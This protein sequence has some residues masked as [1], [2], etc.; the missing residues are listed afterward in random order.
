[1]PAR[2]KYPVPKGLKRVSRRL[3]TGEVR[4]YWYHRATGKRVEG[5]LSAPDG[6]LEVQALDARAKALEAAL[7]HLAGSYADLWEK[8]RQSPEW[9][10]LRPRTRSDYQAVRDWLGAAAE[11]K[12]L[13]SLTTAAVYQLRD[14]AAAEKGRR[15]ANYVVQVLRLTL[16]WGRKRAHCKDNPAKEVELIRK[17]IGEAKVNRAWTAAEVEAFAKAAPFH[18]QIPFALGLFAGMRQGDA[19]MTTW[20]AYDGAGLRWIA[21]KNGE[22]CLAPVS[23]PFKALLD[24]AKNDRGQAVQIAVTMGKQP[25]SASGFR[26]S[27]FKIVRRL[28]KAGA[29][30]PGCTFHGLRLTIASG[31]REAGE[32]DFRVAAAIGDRSTAMASLYG[33]D[34]DRESAQGTVLEGSQKRFANVD[35]K[36][37]PAVKGK[38]TLS[39]RGQKC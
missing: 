16:E 39:G 23:G 15:F 31:A 14:K 4:V 19:L 24:A 32:S 38:R 12:K 5:D 8:Y 21:S 2:R 22:P 35:W 10:A 36:T 33:R 29:M 26:A 34:A 20:S 27:F 11:R 9:R 37:A 17:P 6:L 28:T 13:D 1:L 18:I 30:Q 3:A 7:S 25:W